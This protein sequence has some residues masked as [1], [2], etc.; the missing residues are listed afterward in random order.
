MIQEKTSRLLGQRVSLSVLG[1]G[2]R[3]RVVVRADAPSMLVTIEAAVAKVSSGTL[4]HTLDRSGCV[5]LPRGTRVVL[6]T[7]SP[8]ARVAV[9]TFHDPIFTLVLKRY[10]KLGVDGDRL[11]SFFAKLEVLPRTVWIHEIVHRYVFE[12]Y[13][14]GEHDNSAT[15]FLETEIL[16]EIYFLFRDRSD[17][18]DRASAVRRYSMPV[19]R[20]LSTIELRLFEP[21][22]VVLLA[23]SAGASESTL[24]RSFHRELGCS[25]G[26]YWRDRKLEEAL[27]LLRGGHFSVG[28]IATRIGYE[29]PAGFAFA[30]RRRFGKAPSSFSPRRPARPAP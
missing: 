26:R 10:R 20:A 6:R 16:K 25:P 15:R 22:D 14:L 24:L 21:C 8:A 7:I 29:N 13:D 3:D 2:A 11:A 28:E 30:F 17:G 19:E 23:A 1:L 5:I 4:E 27:V 18:A 12:R 9:V